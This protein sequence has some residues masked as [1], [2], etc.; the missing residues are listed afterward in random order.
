MKKSNYLLRHLAEGIFIIFCIITVN[1]FLIRFM[2]G[3]TVCHILGE[4][5]YFSLMST[6]PEKIEEVRAD[7]GLDKSYPEQF[8]AYLSKTLRL[9]FGNSFRTKN[10]VFSTILFRARWTLWLAIPT[11]FVSGIIGAS[12]GL[13]CGRKNGS[14]LDGLL[15]GISLLISTIPTNCLAILFLVFFAFKAGWFPIS[16]ITS[17]GYTGFAKTLDIFRHMQLPLIIMILYR[18]ASNHL[19]M[20]STAMQIGKSEYIDTA[21]SKGMSERRLRLCHMLKNTLCPYITS[22]CMQFGNVLTG[23][24]MV[25]IVFSWKGMGT[26]IYDSVTSKD[27]PMLQGC[28]LFIGICVVVSNFVADLLCMIIDPRIK[29]GVSCEEI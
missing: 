19:L 15:T 4:D 20:R 21:V 23:A 9:D 18:S 5:E 12:T 2:P 24:M 13:Y 1:F 22:L 28:F 27:F 11:I 14:R 7:Y 6:A 16:G 26:L 29:G 3:D 10:S 8:A 17:G 25:E